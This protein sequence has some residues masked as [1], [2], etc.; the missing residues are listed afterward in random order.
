MPADHAPGAHVA[1][2]RPF[3]TVAYGPGRAATLGP[4]VMPQ[5]C[6]HA[7]K[8]DAACA[9]VVHHRRARKTGPQIPVTVVQCRTHRRAFTL[10]PLGHIPYGR[11][12]VAPVGLDGEVLFATEREPPA[13]GKR[14]PDW[15]AT[16]FGPAFAAIADPTVKLTDPRW[17]ATE[18]PERLAQSA[19]LLGVHPARSVPVADEIAFRLEIPRLVLRQATDEYAR[20]RGRADRGRV[21]VGVLAQLGAD[22]CL[23][24]RVLAAGACAGCWG[25]V[26]RW[27]VATWGARGRIFAGRGAPAG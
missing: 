10:Y 1:G 15:R 27:D 14:S 21:L 17:W 24:D 2:P 16:R 25:T 5:G 18:T 26:T 11:V 22:A 8:G 20:A 13:D 12:A 23:L 6:V 19:A 9:L 4:A 7:S 3:V